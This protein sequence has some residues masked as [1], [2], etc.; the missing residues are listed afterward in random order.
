MSAFPSQ[1]VDEFLHTTRRML[2]FAIPLGALNPLR[3]KLQSISALETGTNMFTA[4]H[5][6]HR[7]QLNVTASFYME[8]N[9]KL[10]RKTLRGS[11]CGS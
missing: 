11:P 7:P 9:S 1:Y 2:V 6:G 3:I 8:T 10:C 4:R 5:L